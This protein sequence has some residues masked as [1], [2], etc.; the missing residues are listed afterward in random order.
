MVFRFQGGRAAKLT[1]LDLSHNALT[2]LRRVE[3]A[4]LTALTSLDLSYNRLASVPA[5]SLNLPRLTSL[6]LASNNIELL[7][8][9]SLGQLAGLQE[10]KLSR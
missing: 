8:S 1:R 2:S 9:E 7:E 4:G 5:G 10:L 6:N 3:L